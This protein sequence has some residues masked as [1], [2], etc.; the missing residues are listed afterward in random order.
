MNK[1]KALFRLN[2]SVYKLC[3]IRKLAE[4]ST[5]KI[6]QMEGRVKKSDAAKRLIWIDCEVSKESFFFNQ[7]RVLISDD[8]SGCTTTPLG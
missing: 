8:R 1:F 7:S 3:S 5:R 6:Q 4:L 2:Q